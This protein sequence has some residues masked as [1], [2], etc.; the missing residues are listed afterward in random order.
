M[1]TYSPFCSPPARRRRFQGRTRVRVMAALTL[2]LAFVLVIF[3]PAPPAR[4]ALSNT[5]PPQISGEARVTHELMVTTGGSNPSVERYQWLRC[6]ASTGG[7]CM[8]IAGET[9]SSYLLT[10]ADL[11]AWIYAQV[12]VYNAAGGWS[13]YVPSERIG[14]ILAAGVDS[15]PG[16]SGDDP[17]TGGYGLDGGGGPVGG[18]SGSGNSGG[19]TGNR[20]QSGTPPQLLIRSL[21]IAPATFRAVRSGGSIGK[22]TGALVTFQVNRQ[23][24]VAFTVERTLPGRLVAGKCVAIKQSNRK[25]RACTR[26]TL[27]RG[28][29]GYPMHG[30][31]PT[32]R[33][34]CRFT[35]RIGNATLTPGTY[36]LVALAE[37]QSHIHSTAVRTGFRIIR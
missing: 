17:D 37:D 15:G 7:G 6:R 10:A 2:L 26:Y 9:W 29:F 8:V 34:K 1:G 36:R 13:D 32:V 21:T 20:V 28:K 4:A 12:S 27:V 5:G 11:N 3:Y 19:R 35:G 30:Y 31:A 23:A 25:A 18:G 16:D 24:Y 14:P 22:K 33:V